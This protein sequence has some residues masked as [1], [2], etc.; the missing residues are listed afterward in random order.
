MVRKYVNIKIL[1]LPLESEIY[2]FVLG[3][4]VCWLCEGVGMFEIINKIKN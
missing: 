1:I 2:H 3:G 4:E